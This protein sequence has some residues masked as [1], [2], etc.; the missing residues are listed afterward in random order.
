MT[1][2]IEH[3]EDMIGEDKSSE[4]RMQ[5]ENLETHLEDIK[6]ILKCEILKSVTLKLHDCMRNVGSP[7]MAV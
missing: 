2:N 4:K 3:K 7:L 1:I 5:N 6:C